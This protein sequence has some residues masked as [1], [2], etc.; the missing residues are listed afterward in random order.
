MTTD[1]D[2][3]GRDEIFQQLARILASKAFAKR[4]QLRRLLNR[5]VNDTLAGTAGRKGYE[6]VLAVEVFEKDE[7]WH[8]LDGAVVRQGMS[9]LRKGLKLY[10][11]AEGVADPIKIIFP[12]RGGYPAQF[13]RRHARDAEATFQWFGDALAQTYFDD[14]AVKEL[15]AS[16][17]THPSYAPGYALLADAILSRAIR[18]DTAV[19]LTPGS[20]LPGADG[21]TREDRHG[22]PRR[23]IWRMHLVAG[24]IHACRCAWRGRKAD[25]SF[26]VALRLAPPMKR[27]AH[28]SYA[29]FLLATSWK[30]RRSKRGG[31]LSTTQA[32]HPAAPLRFR[33]ISARIASVRRSSSEDR[34]RV[35]VSQEDRRPLSYFRSSRNHRPRRCSGCCADV[36]PDSGDGRRTGPDQPGSIPATPHIARPRLHGDKQ[37]RS[38]GGAGKRVCQGT[39]PDALVKSVADLHCVARQRLV[40]VI[41]RE[42][43]FK[44]S[45]PFEAS[46]MAIC[47]NGRPSVR[48]PTCWF[49]PAR[50]ESRRP[51]FCEEC[52]SLRAPG[53]T[54]RY[55]GRSD[56]WLPSAISD[57]WHSR[58]RG[59]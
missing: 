10:D 43:A 25:A 31:A 30:D 46:A 3:P 13:F 21:R 23:R 29:A 18:N 41:D 53:S 49:C 45:Y 4:P 37:Q 51:T 15:E 17:G 5:L 50:R 1:D 48:A 7:K 33:T 56:H 34:I 16:I 59:L 36:V 47:L 54:A 35:A 28:F 39:S 38:Q 55:R 57:R 22:A 26:S 19:S 12:A 24:A 44:R 27:V 42:G 11:D 14:Q 9:H 20:D 6:K 40:H 8:P 32:A 52:I 58:S 2:P